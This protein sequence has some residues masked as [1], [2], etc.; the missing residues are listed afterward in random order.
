M[1][2]DEAWFCRKRRILRRRRREHDGTTTTTIAQNARRNR[3]AEEKEA[4]I[5][6]SVVINVRRHPRAI[7]V[8]PPFLPLS[9]SLFCLTPARVHPLFLIF[10]SSSLRAPS[11]SFPLIIP[12]LYLGPFGSQWRYLACSDWVETPPNLITQSVGRGAKEVAMAVSLHTACT[13]RSTSPGNSLCI[14]FS[15]HLPS[16]YSHFHSLSSSPSLAHFSLPP[17]QALTLK[18]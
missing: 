2:A 6:E 5:V 1:F 8:E 17:K 10:S 3:W 11:V 16:S 15:C 7:S 4:L 9:L 18:D 13:F 14:S 12:Y